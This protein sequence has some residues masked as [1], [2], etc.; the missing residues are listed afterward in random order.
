MYDSKVPFHANHYQNENGGGVAQRVHKLI[1]FTQKVAKHP[2]VGNKIY[3]SLLFG[4]YFVLRGNF[5]NVFFLL[6]F[7]RVEATLSNIYG[8]FIGKNIS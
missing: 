4:W 1:H 8:G 3:G 7:W 6:L 2:T 5:W